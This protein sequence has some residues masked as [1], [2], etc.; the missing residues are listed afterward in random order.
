R[1]A[2]DEVRQAVAVQVAERH[3]GADLRGVVGPGRLGVEHAVAVEVQVGPAVGEVHL[4]Q[5]RAAVAVDVEQVDFLR[6]GEG[7]GGRVERGQR[8]RLVGVDAGR[9]AADGHVEPTV[10]VHVGEGYAAVGVVGPDGGVG[11]GGERAAL[12]EVHRALEVDPLGHAQVR[13]AV[14]V[15]VRHG[16]A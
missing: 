15:E 5:V 7:R 11:R 4:A 13:V 1:V 9:V 8:A 10:P 3:R 16:H 12:V 2:H 6:P 14:V